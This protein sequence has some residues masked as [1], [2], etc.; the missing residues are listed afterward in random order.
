MLKK[1]A[2]YDINYIDKKDR[3]FESKDGGKSCQKIEDLEEKL[4]IYW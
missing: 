4:E 2:S 1:I 3:I